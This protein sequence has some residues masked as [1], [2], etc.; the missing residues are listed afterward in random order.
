MSIKVLHTSDWH[1]GKELH[2]VAL[3]EDMTLFF[4]WLIDFI[5]SKN[6]DVLLMSGDLFDQANP[7]QQA[8]KQ[9]YEFLKSMIPLQCRII[10]TGGNHDSPAVINAPKELL[11]LLDVEVVGGAPESIDELF[12]EFKKGEE[13]VVIAAVPFLRDKDIRKSAP[14]ESYDD[15]IEQ[16]REGLKEYFDQVNINYS[17]HYSGKPFIIMGH[18]FAQGASVSESERD[19]Q[20][21]NQAGVE[22]GIF[23]NQANYIALGHIHKPQQVGKSHIR[24]SGSPVPLSFSEKNDLKEVVLLEFTGTEMTQE[25]HTIPLFRRLVLLDGTL[26]EVRNKISSYSSDSE[27]IDLGEV[28]VREEEHSL[29]TVEGLERLISEKSH[30]NLTI[31]KHKVEFTNLKKGLTKLLAPGEKLVNFKPVDLFLKRLEL[32]PS[33]ENKDELLNAFKEI[34]EHLDENED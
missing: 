14:G 4:R 11:Q 13:S 8:L 28:I 25:T 26:D 29:A 3:E 15:K 24:Y 9:Y 23:G 20:I 1:I 30:S 19:I 21:G 17:N 32:E 7:S 33:L 2:K 27:L 6:I 5:K 12:F 10:L 34:M 18:L 22:F 31:V 16:I